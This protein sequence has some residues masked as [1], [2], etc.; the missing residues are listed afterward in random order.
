MAGTV[1]TNLVDRILSTSEL[2]AMF[3][4]LSSAITTVGCTRVGGTVT[5][6]S[7][8]FV[9]AA[10]TSYGYEVFKLPDG[11]AGSSAVYFKLTYASYASGAG[12]PYMTVEV[13]TGWNSGTGAITGTGS[14][15]TQSLLGNATSTTPRETIVACDD[16][17][18]VIA[19][20]WPSTA[21]TTRFLLLI[22]RQRN[23][24]GTA[25]P[26][27]GW[28]DQ[29]GFCRF[30]T[31]NHVT[32]SVG[33]DLLLVDPA[34]DEATE[35]T[36]WPCITRGDLSS[37]KSMLTTVSPAGVMQVYPTLLATL[38]GTYAS[39]LLVTYPLQDV[40]VGTDLTI[41]HLGADRT[42][43]CLS[44]QFV[45]LSANNVND[46]AAAAVWIGD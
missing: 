36:K 26:V 20:F 43:R 46:G 37:T 34:A 27:P 29:L 32:P 16:D 1:I 7:V 10:N 17:G 39:K 45:Y 2:N 23:A 8:P 18:I 38:Q 19:A 28:A 44:S 11:P 15:I 13:G 42:Y 25:E 3:G 6:G 5:W 33:R 24:D 12:V 30:W 41:P 31:N 35:L 40:P 14:G 4:G 22:D 21:T 9:N